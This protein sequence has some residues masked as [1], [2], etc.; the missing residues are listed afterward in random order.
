MIEFVFVIPPTDSIV[1]QQSYEAIILPPQELAKVL[2]IA[3]QD[4]PNEAFIHCEIASLDNI[5]HILG[6]GADDEAEDWRERSGV[7]WPQE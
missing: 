1:E 7:S 6:R 2:L 4:E 3:T 5:L